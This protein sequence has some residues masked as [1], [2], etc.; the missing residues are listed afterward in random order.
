MESRV[1]ELANNDG[2]ESEDSVI[3]FHEI[4]KGNGE[5]QKQALAWGSVATS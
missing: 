3:R 4:G 1:D 2:H 5:T